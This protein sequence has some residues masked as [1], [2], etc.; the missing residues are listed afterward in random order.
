[1]VQ[2]FRF[3]CFSTIFLSVFF[4]FFF[5]TFFCFLRIYKETNTLTITLKYE[6]STNVC[7]YVFFFFFTYHIYIIYCIFLLSGT[8]VNNIT[9]GK[10]C[11]KIRSSILSDYILMAKIRDSRNFYFFPVF[12]S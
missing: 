1:M 8:K 3:V 10:I 7:V 4:F 5:V 11:T 9:Y 2:S 12:F 6:S